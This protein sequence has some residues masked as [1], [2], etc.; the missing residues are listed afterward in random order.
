M[1][2]AELRAV[3][4]S[5]PAEGA[6]PPRALL[7]ALALQL[8]AAA[9]KPEATVSACSSVKAMGPGTEPAPELMYLRKRTPEGAGRPRLP[10]PSAALSTEA[11]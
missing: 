1:K 8:P 2:G 10:L 4:P 6:A 11:L 7:L 3:R 5:Q 9:L